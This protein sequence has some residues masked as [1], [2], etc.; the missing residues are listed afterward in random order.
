MGGQNARRGRLLSYS[1][2]DR[3]WLFLCILRRMGTVSYTHLDVYKRQEQDLTNEHSNV[4]MMFLVRFV[5]YSVEHPHKFSVITEVPSYVWQTTL[6][7][8]G[9]V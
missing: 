4:E 2:T 6:S 3:A 9:V 1:I 8:D 7:T 5:L